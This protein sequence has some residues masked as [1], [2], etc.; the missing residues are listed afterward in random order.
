MAGNTPFKRW[1]REVHEGG[2]ADPL[3]VAWPAGIAARGEVRSQYV[4]AIDI[5]PTILEVLGFDPPPAIGGVEQRPLDGTSFRYAFDDAA[6]VERH[7]VQYYEMLGCRALYQDGWKAVTYHPIQADEPGLADAPWELYD[8]R[9]DP[10]ELDDLAAAEPQ[11]LAAM[12]ERWWE[13][14]E[15]NQVLPIDNRAF[16]E[17]VLERPEAV[18]ARPRYIYRPGTAPV[19]EAVA[20]NVRNRSHTITAT[21]TVGDD[22]VEGVLLSQG[23]RLGGWTFFLAAG[24]LRYE[25]NRVGAEVH[26]VAGP[27]GLAPGRH[28][29]SFRFSRTGEHAGRG[30]LL[31]D[32]AEVGG[33]DIPRFTPTRFTLTGAGLVC[34]ADPGLT[35]SADYEPP[36]TFSGVLHHV[37]VE[38][39]GDAFLDPEAEAAHAVTTQ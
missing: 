17:F 11:R 18:P 13:E 28:E 23:S 14:A 35:V 26:R 33:G 12:V 39:E 5:A 19:P 1:K 7:T 37:V 10:S 8:L 6:A 9:V 30:T 16:S 38:V 24:E 36:F 32:G 3:I 34:G 22:P 27:A 29:L 25:H 2:V 21:V 20:V 31:V 4:H 15:A